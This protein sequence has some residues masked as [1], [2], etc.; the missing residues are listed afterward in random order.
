MHLSSKTANSFV[1]ELVLVP[2][3]WVFLANFFDEFF[4]QIFFDEL[5]RFF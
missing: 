5:G 1:Y 3:V 2:M 4:K